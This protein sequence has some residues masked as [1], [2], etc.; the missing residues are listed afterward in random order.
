MQK[1]KSM[2][3]AIAFFLG[4]LL[5]STGMIYPQVRGKALYDLMEKGR[6]VKTEG[7]TEIIWH[8]DGSGYIEIERDKNKKMTKS[9][10]N[11][12][13]VLPFSIK[14]PRT[15]SLPSTSD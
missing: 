3:L 14:R 9:M 4:F 15:G 13:H 8:P 10:Q 2:N 11:L 6:L 12:G 5:L 1:S 7:T